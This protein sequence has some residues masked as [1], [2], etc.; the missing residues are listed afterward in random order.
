MQNVKP[1]GGSGAA[2]AAR[3]CMGKGGQTGRLAPCR[4]LLQQAAKASFRINL[5]A[6]PV[7]MWVNLII[8]V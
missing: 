1:A 7:F 6:S 3:F 5:P 4:Y 2:Q 8:P